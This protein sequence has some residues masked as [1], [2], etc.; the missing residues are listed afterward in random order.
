MS[1]KRCTN[2]ELFNAVY[3]LATE[4]GEL[5]KLVGIE[6]YH[7]PETYDVA[8]LVD[9]EF[10][11]FWTANYGGSEGIYI[12]AYLFG[13]FDESKKKKALKLGTVKTLATG[14][15]A[16]KIMGEACGVLSYFSNQYINKNLD[17]FT[18][19]ADLRRWGRWE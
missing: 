10:D 17:N 16:M 14:L 8:T 18:P 12:D 1:I 2:T 15:E 5:A 19:E 11:C 7:L 6:D 3:Q 4:S 9:H 13:V